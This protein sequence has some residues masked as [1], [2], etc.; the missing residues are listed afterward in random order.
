MGLSSKFTA[1]SLE[2]RIFRPAWCPFYR[3]RPTFSGMDREKER[4]PV[5]GEKSLSADR[6]GLHSSP[7]PWTEKRSCFA[8]ERSAAGVNLVRK[9]KGKKEVLSLWRRG[10]SL[11]FGGKK[12]CRRER[13][14]DLDSLLWGR[15]KSLERGKG[16]CFRA[17]QRGGR[18]EGPF[19]DGKIAL[20]PHR[21]RPNGL[22][23]N[24]RSNVGSITP[25]HH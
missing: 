22:R 6:K 24:G 18:E 17:T 11:P 25:S 10:G 21:V 16:G 3:P 15:R 19:P 5:A 23:R 8:P 2:E 4:P 12:V 13:R 1:S 7:S 20:L 14:D 9:K